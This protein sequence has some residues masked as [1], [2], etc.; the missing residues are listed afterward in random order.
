MFFMELYKKIRHRPDFFIVCI[1]DS[2]F[3]S[4]VP[5]RSGNRTISRR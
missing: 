5:A 1:S 4:I 2:V 3:V